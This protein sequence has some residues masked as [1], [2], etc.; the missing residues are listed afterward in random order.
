M[1]TNQRRDILRE[2][3][4]FEEEAHAQTGALRLKLIQD[5]NQKKAQLKLTREEVASYNRLRAE[6]RSPKPQHQQPGDS[7][8]PILLPLAP[9]KSAAVNSAY[10]AFSLI[11]L[12]ELRKLGQK[13]SGF[14]DANSFPE[15]DVSRATAN[16]FD[17]LNEA[18]VLSLLT[19]HEDEI[20]R[21]YTFERLP[22]IDHVLF[23]PG[24]LA[25]MAHEAQEGP[26]IAEQLGQP[27][28]TRTDQPQAERNWRRIARGA[29]VT[30]MNGIYGGLL[31]A[32]C[33]PKK[34][35]WELAPH[36]WEAVLSVYTG[37]W[38]IIQGWRGDVVQHR[39]NTP[40]PAKPKKAKPAKPKKAKPGA[41]DVTLDVK[42]RL[43]D[44]GTV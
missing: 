24:E 22:A 31:V 20:R 43:R 32:G 42:P 15:F 44:D 25:V 30:C 17:T 39:P 14:V 23:P 10:A 4:R 8:P 1:A 34:G 33:V 7:M 28:A 13:F 21:T 16:L 3:A 6:V 5:A 37:V 41:A 40:R 19:D 35:V 27:L 29:V 11:N 36:G 9:P 2:L 12:N 26:L 18:G 38:Q